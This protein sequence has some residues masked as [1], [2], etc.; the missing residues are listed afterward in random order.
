MDL[1][2]VVGKLSVEYI[3]LLNVYDEM[4]SPAD[5]RSPDSISCCI[6]V[7]FGVA[8]L[9]ARSVRTL[10]AALGRI[11][12]S[13]AMCFTLLG[14]THTNKKNVALSQLVTRNKMGKVC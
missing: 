9:R 14:H 2:G 7:S 5:G 1:V 10:G 6:R 3:W 11:C 13:L 4:G 8:V 12:C